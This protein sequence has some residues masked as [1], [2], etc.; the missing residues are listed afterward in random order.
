MKGDDTSRGA[1]RARIA[2]A[3]AFAAGMVAGTVVLVRL[4]PTLATVAAVSNPT[5]LLDD[6]TFSATASNSPWQPVPGSGAGVYRVV[7]GRRATRGVVRGTIRQEVPLTPVDARSYRLT[8]RLRSA[9]GSGSGTGVLRLQTACVAGQERAESRFAAT[10]AWSFVAVTLV[11]RDAKACSLRVEVATDRSSAVELEDASLVDAMLRNASFE[12][13]AS[14][15]VIGEG[16]ATTVTARPVT[17]AF[18]GGAVGVLRTGS[19]PGSIAQD[20]MLDQSSEPVLARAELMVRTGGAPTL[21][22]LRLW[23][24][25]A[26]TFAETTASVTTGWTALSVGQKR[27]PAATTGVVPPDPPS[28]IRPD[29]GPCRVRVELRSG[30]G[31]TIE[32]DSGALVLQSYNPT[33][34]SPLYRHNLRAEKRATDGVTDNAPSST[35]ASRDA[36]RKPGT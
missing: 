11:P 8:V 28:L 2:I 27:I 19:T 33:S 10:P 23:A 6:P 35:I 18:D 25:C 26:S 7:R 21:V 15:W 12:L 29:G 16:A 4:N 20:V 31:A 36:G 3:V 34:G 22:S 17:D 24:P 13:G 30:P 32:V 14:D 9:P 1:S 5:E